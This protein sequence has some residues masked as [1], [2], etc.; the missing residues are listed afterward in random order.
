MNKCFLLNPEKM[1]L[2]R[3]VIFEKN[4]KPFN[5]N[6]LLF[7]KNDVIVS[8]AIGQH[9]VKLVSATI[10]KQNCLKK[11]SKLKTIAKTDLYWFLVYSSVR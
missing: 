2:I 11:L 8:K 9:L 4:L 6:A 1:A 10:C 7:Q 5:S 3:A